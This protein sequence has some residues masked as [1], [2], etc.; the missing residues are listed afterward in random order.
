M[1]NLSAIDTF[2]QQWDHAQGVCSTDPVGISNDFT[3]YYV[4]FEVA[5]RFN[6]LYKQTYWLPGYG[7]GGGTLTPCSFTSPDDDPASVAVGWNATLSCPGNVPMNYDAGPP[8]VGPTCGDVGPPPLRAAKDTGNSCPGGCASGS[9]SGVSGAASP[10]GSQT[11]KADPVSASNGNAYIGETDYVSGANALRFVRSYNSEMAGESYGSGTG[12]SEFGTTLLGPGWIATYFQSLAV[13][14]ITDSTGSYATVQAYRP[15]GRVELFNLFSGV[16]NPEPDVPDRLI[17]TAGGGWELQTDNDTL[18]TYNSNG[19]LLSVA[20]RG[21]APITISYDPTGSWPVSAS[22]IAGHTL[23]FG[24]TSDA[25]SN[26][27]HLVSVTDP[28]G[29]LIQYAYD[30][31]GNNNL[32]SVTYQD[33]SSRTYVY[34][35]NDPSDHLITNLVDEA[36]TTYE[37][38][39]YGYGGQASATQLAGGVGA[40][41]FSYG[42]GTSTVTDPLGSTINY[43]Q[44][45]IW[46]VN[47]TAGADAP[48]IGCGE[49]ASRTFDA[50]GNITLRTDFNGNQTSYAYDTSRNLETSRTEAYG[51]SQARTITTTWDASWRQPDLVTEPYRKTAYTYDSMG[52]TLTRTVTDTAASPNTTRVW[53]YTYDSDGRVLTAKGP[54]TD[55]NST[56]TYAYYTGTTGSQ[57]GRLHTVTDPAGN[58]TTYNTYNAYGQPLTIA[59]PNGIVTTLTYDARQRLMSRS[60]SSD[61]TGFAYYATGL[62]KTVTLPDSSTL[63]YTY[64]AAHRLTQIQDSLGNSMQYT[65]DAMGNRTAESAYDPSSTLDRTLSRVYNTLNEL[66]QV[67]GAAGTSAVTTTY[68]YDNN[69]NQT[70]VNA[71]LS[72]NTTNVFDALNRLSQITDPNNGKASFGYDENDDLTSVKDPKGKT[73]TYAYTGYGDLKSQ[74]SPDTGTTTL[75]YDSGGN[76]FTS[77][78]ARGDTATYSYDAANRVTQVA[79]GDQTILYSYDLGTNGR[80]RLVGASDAKHSISWQYDTLGRMD[81]KSQTVAGVTKTVAYDYI[82]GDL[83]GIT[84]PSGQSVTYGYTNHQITSIAI[85]GATLLSGAVYEAFGPLRGWSWGNGTSETRLYDTDGNPNQM[86]GIE[87]HSYGLDSAFRITGI[88]NASNP[89]LNWTYGYDLLDRVNSASGAGLSLGWT[90]DANGNRL[91]QSAGGVGTTYTISTSNNRLTS[92]TGGQARTYT[93]DADGD[94]LTYG[95]NTFTYNHRGRMATAKVSSVTTSYVYNALG[96]RIEKSGGPAGTTLFMYDGAGHLIGEY[97]STGALIEET[98]YLG[99]TPVAVIQMV[100]TTPTVYYVHADHLNTPIMITQ[101]SSNAIAWRWDRDPFGTV[102]PN[103]N[104]AGLGT[105][106]YNPRFPGQYYDQ[107]TGLNY[108]YKR[109]YDPTTGRFAESDPLGLFAGVATYSYANASPIRYKDPLGMDV[110]IENTAAVNGW[111]QHISVDTPA[112]PYAISYGMDSRDNPEQGSTAASGVLPTPGGVGNG[113]VYEDPDPATAVVETLPTTPAQDSLIEQLL[114][115]QVGKRGPYNFATNSCRTFSRREFNEIRDK[116]QAPWWQQILYNLFGAPAY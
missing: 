48:C 91:T 38:W 26:I 111:H 1:A 15:D 98:V 59:D 56:T 115:Q 57:C 11:T 84:T 40:Y 37:S 23:Q 41:N 75:T 70:T 82:G 33:G 81:S 21:Q 76:L 4:G 8:V 96:Q 110:R 86:A 6:R 105:F 94:V 92:S 113:M 66:Y 55:V 60:T 108:N 89:S 85:N 80:G 25:V 87:S 100:G 3:T 20:A 14:S 54:R 104:P 63:T 52:N 79:Y 106:V 77:K 93:F 39:S 12:S 68:G 51:T 74:V 67:V 44:Q 7:G 53:T 19:Q 71:P 9:T 73:T 46:G 102:A 88:S 62:L 65:L 17:Q 112:G 45:L 5:D 43:T 31:S 18:E 101:P 24:Y 64:D 47:H 69:G 83:T 13:S 99:D 42:S 109:D 116:L 61:T 36:G 35:P 28:A 22:D 72:R 10:G 78:D 49:D 58:V 32:T 2:Y 30:A 50:N 97:S 107:E 27:P 114:R 90:Y 95:S 16:Y 103:Q 34:D 29:A